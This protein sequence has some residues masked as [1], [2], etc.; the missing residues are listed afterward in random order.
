[1]RVLGVYVSN[2]R[3]IGTRGPRKPANPRKIVVCPAACVKKYYVPLPGRRKAITGN[4][5]NIPRRR[6]QD[7]RRR[8]TRGR[9]YDCRG[10]TL[11]SKYGQ[12]RAQGGAQAIADALGKIVNKKCRDEKARPE[13]V[14][15][16]R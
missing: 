6:A 9:G 8:T 1:M 14:R 11:K 4:A 7:A 3:K 5:A 2:A 15:K 10:K 12:N 16:N 13:I